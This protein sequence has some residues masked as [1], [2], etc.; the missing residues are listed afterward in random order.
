[1]ANTWPSVT[2]AP[3]SGWLGRGPGRRRSGE[4]GDGDSHHQQDR[5]EAMASRVHPLSA[6]TRCEAGLT[7]SALTRVAA[8]DVESVRG[9]EPCPGGR[10]AGRAI[11][12][13]VAGKPR[14]RPARCAL[15]LDRLD[16]VPGIA[17]V[18]CREDIVPPREL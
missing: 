11:R 8:C 7:P 13:P 9:D 6:S 10:P 18:S 4:R 17:E 3:A 12:G 2:Q 14:V 16:I 1:M 15:T 5:R